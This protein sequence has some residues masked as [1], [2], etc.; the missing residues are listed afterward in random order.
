V[1]AEQQN[2]RFHGLIMVSG[3]PGVLDTAAHSGTQAGCGDCS[4]EVI[5]A[6]LHNGPNQTEPDSCTGAADAPNCGKGQ[7]LYR[8]FLSTDAVQNQLVNLLCLGGIGDVV[9]VG[10]VAAA[11]VQRYLKDVT[12]PL[13]GVTLDPDKGVPAG[14][15][16][17]FTVHAPAVAPAPFGGAQVAETITIAPTRYRWAWGDGEDSGWTTDTGG[18][19]PSGTLTRT[20]VHAGRYHGSVTTEWAG[21]YTITVAGQTFGPYNAIG[22]VSRTQPFTADVL[23]ARTHLVSHG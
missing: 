21:T 7:L 1:T 8:V 16:T 12:P 4:W 9:P 18:P 11:D 15:P 22:T 13:V 2:G 23:S 14:L 10:D 17:Y 6:C 20:Y 19:Y 3:Q 5:L